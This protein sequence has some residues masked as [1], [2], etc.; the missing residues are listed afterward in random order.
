M[1]S[2]GNHRRREEHAASRV[3]GGT[4][5]ASAERQRLL[6]AEADLEGAIAECE[7]ALEEVRRELRRLDTH[8]PL[9]GH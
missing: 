6:R 1:R 7:A 8:V 3:P 5:D 4:T 2:L 9:I